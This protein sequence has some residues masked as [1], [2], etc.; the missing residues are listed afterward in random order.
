MIAVRRRRVAGR[1]AAR[2]ARGP[3]GRRASRGGGGRRA[4]GRRARRAAQRRPA[5]QPEPPRR[6]RGGRRPSRPGRTRPADGPRAAADSRRP[7][8]R[9]SA[10]VERPAG[11]RIRDLQDRLR[12]GVA[13]APARSGS[14][15]GRRR[16]ALSSPV[17]ASGSR[18]S[19]R[20]RA[21]TTSAR[22]P[23]LAQGSHSAARSATRIGHAA[24]RNAARAAAE[25]RDARG[26]RETRLNR[27]TSRPDAGYHVPL[28]EPLVRVPSRP[29]PRSASRPSWR[30]SAASPTTCGGAWHPRARVLFTRIDAGAWARYRNPIPVLQGPVDWTELLDNPRFMAEYED[31]LAR[32]RRATWPTA[33]DHWFHAPARSELAGPDRLLLRRVRPPRVARHLLRR[34]GRARRRPHEDGLGHGAAARRRRP[35]VPPRLL[36]PD[37]RRRRPPGARLPRLRP[38]PAADPAGPGPR[39]ASRLT[40]TRRSCPGRDLSVAVWAAQ[41]GPRAGP[42][43]RHGHPRER[44]RGPA[45]HPHPVRPRPRDAAPPGAGPRASAASGRCARSGSAPAVW[46]LNEGHSAFL[47]AERAREQVGRWRDARR[48]LDDRVAATACSRSTPPSRRATSASTPTSSGASPARCSTATAGPD[49]RRPGAT[50][51]L[52]LGLGVDGD[53]TQFD[54]T[55]FSLRLTQR[56]QRRQPAPRPD[57]ERR[58]G[59]AWRR[60]RSWA[61]PTASTRRRWVGPA[62]AR[63]SSSA[64]STRTSTRLDHERRG[65]PLLGARRPRFP[66]ADLWEAHQRQK[67]ELSDL[68]PRPA[69]QPVRPPRR[70]ARRS[71]RSSRRSSTRAS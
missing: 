6:C 19:A 54:M 50:R 37:D 13:R 7:R 53:P 10:T 5:E 15:A 63:T 9:G 17:P 46:H 21:S 18:P 47:L 20:A 16:R 62:D 64:T 39:T 59:T 28:M 45:D 66:T 14:G 27:F 70:G 48:G 12:D 49:R 40:V 65:A 31:V 29:A 67:L 58:P 61:S 55:A 35:A 24:D 68:R 36:P 42:P 11:A 25:L 26:R 52:E 57:R 38:G 60:T 34:P 2:R 30:A 32:V 44:R 69:A 4:A 8:R 71:S 51:L 22:P 33:R 56:R 41:V 43:A 1:L 23:V 3:P